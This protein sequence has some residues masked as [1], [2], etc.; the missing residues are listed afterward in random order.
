[1]R[2][3]PVTYL[4]QSPYNHPTITLQSPYTDKEIDPLELVLGEGIL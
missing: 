1:M 3:P 2:F 4:L